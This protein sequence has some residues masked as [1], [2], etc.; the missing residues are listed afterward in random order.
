MRR[1]QYLSKRK[2]QWKEKIVNEMYSRR[3]KQLRIHYNAQ[4][5]KEGNLKK[6]YNKR[7]KLRRLNCY[8]FSKRNISAHPLVTISSA[9]Y[10]VVKDNCIILEN[11]VRCK[12]NRRNCT[13]GGITSFDIHSVG[14]NIN[15]FITNNTDDNCLECID[16][17]DVHS[18][19]IIVLCKVTESGLRNDP[20]ITFIPSYHH[21][22]FAVLLVLG[23]DMHQVVDTTWIPTW[24]NSRDLSVL[25]KFKK[26]TVKSGRSNHHYGSSGY[27][28]SFGIRNAFSRNSTSNIT[29]THY[30][31]DETRPA[32]MIKSSIWQTMDVTFKYLDSIIM[33]LSNNL[34]IFNKSMQYHA[35]KTE[36]SCYMRKAIEIN[37][38]Y[39]IMSS[40]NINIEACTKFLHCE[41]DTTYTTLMVPP[42][43]IGNP[44]IE[45]EFFF[46]SNCSL[47]VLLRPFSCVA[48][49]AYCLSHRQVR[50]NGETCM[51]L[52]TYSGRRL[53][54]NYRKS[55]FRVRL[56]KKF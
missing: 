41:R 3:E 48:Y 15:R 10:E 38:R 32:T 55:L 52:S 25:R 47:N 11:M 43:T 4:G 19:F 35:K 34:Y 1:N 6:W 46:G 37:S 45:F 17:D 39:N 8:I 42:Q 40:G 44:F 9:T 33:G 26:S 22:V 16:V 7:K 2:L 24:D 53:F 23:T 14:I 29:I 18:G 36:L 31:G 5:K 30:A 13:D 28:Y 12:V 51:N 20:N 54:N 56:K 49:S 21:P 50:Y 27:C